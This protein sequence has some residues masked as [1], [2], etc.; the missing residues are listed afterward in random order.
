VHVR[1]LLVEDDVLLGSSTKVGLEQDGFAV[2]WV[3]DADAADRALR[4]HLYDAVVLDLG[5]PG[6]DGETVLREWRARG[7]RT[8]VVVLTGRGYVLDRV[9][10][11]NLG[12][13]DYLVKPFDLTELAARVRAV[14]R[15]AAG[16]SGSTLQVGQLQ[17]IPESQT[18]IWK[19][20]PVVVT[21]KEFWLLEA[22][23]RNK[24]RVLTRRQ[25][26]DALYGWGDEVESNA[27]EVHIH[28]LRRKISRDLILTVRG[29]GYGLRLDAVI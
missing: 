3:N 27:V 24:N 14:V 28:H 2:D 15:R 6:T 22:L 7:E 16:T 20:Q 9:R 12:A 19:G 5:L 23:V 13:D 25:L 1:L 8:A 26:E 4:V 18:V 17:L 11:L 21:S 10:L 29:A